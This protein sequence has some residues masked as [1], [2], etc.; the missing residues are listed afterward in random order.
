[1]KLGIMQPYFIPY[2]GYFQLMNYVDKYVVYDDVNF[3]KGGWINRNRIL[4]NNNEEIQLFNIRM[5]GASS[6][7]LINEIGVQNDEIYINKLLKTIKSTYKNAPYFTDTYEIIE[8]ILKCKE[9]NLGKYIFN[10]IKVLSQKLNIKTEIILSS[11]LKKDNSLK[12]SQK[13]M[14]ICNI[15]SADTYVNS[16]GG[17]ELY[18]YDE[19][20][21]NNI[22]LEFLKTREIKYEQNNSDFKSNLSIIDVLMFNSPSEIKKFLDDF[23]IIKE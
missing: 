16:I 18:S 14:H 2:I 11:E 22:T 3:I 4:S 5:S 7:K 17:K 10:S 21:K 19:F 8:E 23:D 12:A 1:M 13:V 20:R 6:T 9:G 15:L